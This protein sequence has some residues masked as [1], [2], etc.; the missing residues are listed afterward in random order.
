MPFTRHG[1]PCGIRLPRRTAYKMSWPSTS[2]AGRPCLYS[3][4]TPQ[5]ARAA[6]VHSTDCPALSCKP[7]PSPQVACHQVCSCIPPALHL[8]PTS[9][10]ARGMLLLQRRLLPQH[11]LTTRARES[12]SSGCLP[13]RSPTHVHAILLACHWSQPQRRQQPTSCGPAIRLRPRAAGA[14][15]RR[16]S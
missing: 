8:P 16:R 13:S 6:S 7:S 12:G 15:C 5:H 1:M 10:T 4:L 14:A 2:T 9:C 3:I 11:T